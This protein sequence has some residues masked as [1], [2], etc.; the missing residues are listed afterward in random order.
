MLRY[1]RTVIDNNLL[2]SFPDFDWKSIKKIRNK[3]Y[4]HLTQ[5]G[6]EMLKMI[7]MSRKNVMRRYYCSNT[8]IVNKFYEEGKSV[9]LM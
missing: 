4:W 6:V 8:E 5:I 2:K 3:F 9:V 7:S 1:R